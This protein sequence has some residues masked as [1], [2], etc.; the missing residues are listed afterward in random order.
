LLLLFSRLCSDLSNISTK[1]I[2]R[3]YHATDLI[4]G[5]CVGTSDLANNAVTSAKIGAG[6]VGASDIA[7]SAVT[8]SKI[9]DTNSVTSVDILNG[10]VTSAD[11]RDGTIT[12][13][14]I[15]PGAIPSGGGIPADN[16]V[17]SEK[18]V[19]AE[20]TLMSFLFLFAKK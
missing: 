17:T 15:A 8:S 13:K 1:A 5:G 12:S 18:I 19:D 2:S 14:D 16:S 4:C 6:Q 3:S 10:E 7:N 11:I 20:L 9:S